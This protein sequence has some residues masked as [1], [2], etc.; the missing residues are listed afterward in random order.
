MMFSFF[1]RKTS[2]Y[3]HKLK[4]RH[5]I[6]AL[7]FST[8]YVSVPWEDLAGKEFKDRQNYIDYLEYGQSVLTYLQFENIVDYVTAEWLWHYMLDELVRSGQM[9]PDQFFLVISFSLVFLYSLIVLG[10]ASPLYLFLLFNPLVVDF[11]FTQLRHA[12]AMVFIAMSIFTRAT[13]FR[14]IL[15][16]L[17]ALVHTSSVLFVGIFYA[18]KY[19]VN[20]YRR[21]K[22]VLALRAKIVT[23]GL[24]LSVVL[25]PAMSA[26]LSLVGDRRA[27][28]RDLSSTITYLS[29]WILVSVFM[30]FRIQR[31]KLDELTIFTLILITTVAFN[32]L[33][34]G[35]SLRVLSVVFPF[36]LVTLANS[37][38]H[39][40][41]PIL[42]AFAGYS[43]LQWLYWL[44]LI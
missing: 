4:W 32:A 38:V 34:G 44:R 35:Y 11:G 31:T 24:G 36:Y 6:I 33:T 13:A 1:K 15:L 26:V 22:D 41:L 40:R 5:V 30:L 29:I 21:S 9:T 8:V 43:F 2:V 42:V 10:N 37:A 20:S 3:E 14:I 17:S 19:L 18:S 25:G 27:V 28:E 39:V 23:L 12:L 16:S 7:L